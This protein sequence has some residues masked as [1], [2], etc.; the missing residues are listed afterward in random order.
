MPAVRIN[1]NVMIGWP[2]RAEAVAVARLFDALAL[3]ALT[4]ARTRLI[5]GAAGKASLTREEGRRPVG[6]TGAIADAVALAGSTSPTPCSTTVT[7][8]VST[9]LSTTVTLPG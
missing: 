7:F 2:V 6:A 1:S 4:A 5:A 8:P 3:E 9:A